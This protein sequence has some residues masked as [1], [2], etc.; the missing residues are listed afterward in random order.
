MKVPAGLKVAALAACILLL[1]SISGGS[2][3]GA[4]ASRSAA[5]SAYGVQLQG[6]VPI[7]ARPTVEASASGTSEETAEDSLVHVPAQ[8]AA[9]SFT[10]LVQ[11]GASGTGTLDARLQAVIASAFD[12]VPTGWNGRGYA[13]TEDLVALAEALQA[14]VIESESVAGCV[15]GEVVYGSA[16]R[17][18]GLTLGGTAVPIPNPGPNQTLIDQGGIRIVFW[19]TNWDPQTGGTSDGESVW[20][21][22]LHITAPGGVDLVVSHSEANVDCA[23][24]VAPLPPREEPPDAPA[25][26]VVEN[27]PNFTG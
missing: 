12:A 15:G 22:A 13:V 4:Q 10:A 9:E 20:T 16:A 19:E 5:G 18:V 1:G 3:V 21:N 23:P 6:P 24:E 2:S 17:V 11:A 14:Q 25:A 27:P 26:N 7:T 8:P